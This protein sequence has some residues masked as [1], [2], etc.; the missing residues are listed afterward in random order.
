MSGAAAENEQKLVEAIAETHKATGERLVG[1]HSLF[2]QEVKK[3][4]ESQERKQ[5]SREKLS[6]TSS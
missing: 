4:M 6:S 5:E 1:S 3:I 2:T